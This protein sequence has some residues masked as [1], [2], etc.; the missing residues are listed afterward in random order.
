MWHVAVWLQPNLIFIISSWFLL[1]FFLTGKPTIQSFIG[2]RD[3]KLYERATFT[4]IIESKHKPTV[5]WLRDSLP[6]PP[7]YDQ[8]ISKLGA[9]YETFLTIQNVSVADKA[10]FTCRAEDMVVDSLKSAEKTRSMNV[11]CKLHPKLT[12]PSNFSQHKQCR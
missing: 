9:F 4:C 6:V 3:V 1:Y 11:K 8:R 7:E 10:T 12:N 5:T 2:P